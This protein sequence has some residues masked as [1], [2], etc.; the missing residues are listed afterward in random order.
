MKQKLFILMCGLAICSSSFA[1]FKLQSDSKIGMGTLN[2]RY[3]VDLITKG[4]SNDTIMIGKEYHGNK[5]MVEMEY[6][7][8]NT[9]GRSGYSPIRV[10]YNR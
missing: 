7:S 10:S 9:P 3:N 1:Q 4:S 8:P 2:P 6:A 5:L